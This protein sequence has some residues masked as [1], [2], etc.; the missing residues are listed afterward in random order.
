[1]TIQHAESDEQIASTFDVMRQLRTHLVRE[2]YVALVRELMATDGFRIAFLTD[3]GQV[4]AV[5]G[6]RFMTMLYCGRVL[7]VDDLVTD[8][9]RRSRGAGRALLGFLDGHARSRGCESLVL[10]SGT[11]RRDAHRFYFREGL[12]IVAFHFARPLHAPRGGS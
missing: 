3:D 6:Y 11:W 1:M 2:S 8:E 12:A 9:A 5:A 4:R 10:D 7:Y